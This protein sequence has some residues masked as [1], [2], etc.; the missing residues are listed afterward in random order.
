MSNPEA[1]RN[2]AKEN[3]KR[4]LED[5]ST[6]IRIPSISTDPDHVKDMTRAAEWVAEQLDGFGFA[7]TQV[8]PTNRHPVVYGKYDQAGPDAPTILI[9]GHYDVQPVDPLDEWDSDP[10]EPTIREENLFARG[11]SD[12]KGQIVAQLKAVESL[13]STTGLPVNLI[14]M[15]EGEEEIGSPNLEAF[16]LKN[17]SLFN[18]DFCLNADSGILGAETPSLTYAL[19]GLAYF[20]INLKGPSSDLHS[21]TFGGAIE[22]P[23]NVLCDLIAGMRDENGRVTLPGFYDSVIPLGEDE[24]TELARLPQDDEWWK[25][26]SGAKALRGELGYSSVERATGRPTLDVNGILSGFIG[27]GSKTVLPSRA[28]AK[29]SMRL[30][31]DQQPDQVEQSLRTYLEE[32]MPPTMSWELMKHA[33]SL[34]GMIDLESK[35]A[36]AAV[37]ALETVWGKK[38]L[39][40]RE[41]GSVPVVG[42]LKEILDI[43]SLMLG[44]GLP[45]DNLHAPN[46]KIYLPNYYRGI[47]TYIRFIQNIANN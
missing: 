31:P 43:N 25:E 35:E 23:A 27:E 19:R 10:F 7:D 29:V 34:P 13:I 5:L 45:D 1:A 15:I 39:Y 36:K 47:E 24:R 44:F 26:Q 32:N 28:M 6:F 12:M 14:Y 3:S 17:E 2:F 9:Y 20:E 42:L 8:M 38:P 40:K 46:E 30:V 41:G 37:S 33:G 11:A 18:C 21:G 22:N 4:F 16:I